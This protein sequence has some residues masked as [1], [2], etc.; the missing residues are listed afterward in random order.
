MN[1]FAG[2]DVSLETVAICIIDE[3]G[4]VLWR[5]QVEGHP[6]AVLDA[7]RD[8]APD[9]HRVVLE[10]GTTSE[11]IGGHLVD[12]GLP[13]VCLE[14]RHV[15]SALGAMTVKTDRSAPRGS[16]RSPAPAGSSRCT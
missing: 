3:A 10:A 1:Y 14:T 4:V 16:R 13:A 15:K 2:L 6:M 5:G 12:A 11:W 7:L 8:W 9:L